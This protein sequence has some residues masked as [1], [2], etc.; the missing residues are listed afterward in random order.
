MTMTV[1]ITN[2]VVTHVICSTVTPREPMRWGTATLTIDASIAPI[3]VPKVIESVTSHLLTGGR[4]VIAPPPPL[5]GDVARVPSP[6]SRGEGGRRPDEGSSRPLD[7]PPDVA[8]RMLQVVMRGGGVG[9]RG[10]QI[11]T[12]LAIA[13]LRAIDFHRRSISG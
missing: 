2:P 6:R 13:V 9:L 7:Q 10:D 1:A 8:G 3:S 4:S 12:R 11:L 5:R